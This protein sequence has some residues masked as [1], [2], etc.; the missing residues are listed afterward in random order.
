MVDLTSETVLDSNVCRSENTC[1]HKRTDAKDVEEE[2]TSGFMWRREGDWM[3][4]THKVHQTKW[5]CSV[6]MVLPCQGKDMTFLDKIV[7]VCCCVLTNICPSVVMK[8]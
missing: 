3:C 4:S 2:L 5:T 6:S 1:I 7:T 8:S